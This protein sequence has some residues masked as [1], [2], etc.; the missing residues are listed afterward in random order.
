MRQIIDILREQRKVS[1]NSFNIV[2]EEIVHEYP[3]YRAAYEALEI[4][5][6]RCNGE[7][8]YADY[9]SFRQLRYRR[10]KKRCN[11]R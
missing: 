10:V 7:R 2:F 1:H 3:S 6:E 9:A 11:G 8:R 4:E 5:Y